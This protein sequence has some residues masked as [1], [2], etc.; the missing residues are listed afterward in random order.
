MKGR[1][2]IMMEWMKARNGGSGREGGRKDGRTGEEEM[3]N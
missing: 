3:K 2:E 1:R